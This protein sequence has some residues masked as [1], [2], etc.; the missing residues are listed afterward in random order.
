MRDTPDVYSGVKN[1]A[2]YNLDDNY[3]AMEILS[4][5]SRVVG[6]NILNIQ[7]E[8]QR[9]RKDELLLDEQKRERRA[10]LFLGDAKLEV[11]SSIINGLSEIMRKTQ[12]VEEQLILTYKL[13]FWTS[14]YYYYSSRKGQV[15]DIEEKANGIS[16]KN[17]NFKEN[18]KKK[19]E[20]KNKGRSVGGEK[21]GEN[22][23]RIG[24]IR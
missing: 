18:G 20:T 23:Q 15:N 17:N 12:R 3:S 7:I 4:V 5:V 1:L 19:E 11:N 2:I 21:N 14:S 16:E 9:N 8:E 22:V 24:K 13:P 6:K 10:Y